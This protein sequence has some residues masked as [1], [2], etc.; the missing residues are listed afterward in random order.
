MD[1]SAV[2]DFTP[3]D[4]HRR[5]RAAK[6]SAVFG[7]PTATP[8]CKAL[9]YCLSHHVLEGADRAARTGDTTA[10]AW[11]RGHRDAGAAT[12][13][14]PT[15]VGP[16]VVIS[17]GIDALLRSPAAETPYIVLGHDT[18][19]AP[20]ALAALAARACDDASAAGFARLLADHAAVICLLRA[21]Q[22]GDTLGSWTISRLPGT[23]F[24][25]HTGDPAIL[26]RDLIHEAGHNWLNDALA[27]AGC[28][29][30]ADVRYHSPWK[31]TARPAF[32]FIHA[33]WAFPLTMLYT[34]QAARSATEP[35]RA[36]L[37]RYLDQQRLLLAHAEADHLRALAHITDPDLRERLRS[38]AAAALAL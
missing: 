5:D 6:I 17:P 7:W 37:Q 15:A 21:R 18:A 2:F 38:V 8:D 1:L 31:D 30:P 11:Y 33:C 26:G 10:F 34:A 24:T 14:T 35:V 32:G 23:V 29:I 12:I 13:L 20:A 28:V 22:P 19:P 27:A 36:F 3:I 9:D 4:R 25:D 16:R